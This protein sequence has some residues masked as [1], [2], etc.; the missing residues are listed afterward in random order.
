M[1]TQ[2]LQST[3]ISNQESCIALLVKAFSEDPAVRWM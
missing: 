2:L 1:T 3:S